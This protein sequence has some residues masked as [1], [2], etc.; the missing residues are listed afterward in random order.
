[1]NIIFKEASEW[2][3]GK[4]ASGF[5][6]KRETLREGLFTNVEADAIIRILPQ[7][8]ADNPDQTY[9]NYHTNVKDILNRRRNNDWR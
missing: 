9:W 6:I 8:D 1:M 5:R 2:Q 7:I 4:I 3:L